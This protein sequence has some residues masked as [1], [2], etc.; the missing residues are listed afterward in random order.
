MTNFFAI[1]GWV[2]ILLTLSEVG[3]TTWRMWRHWQKGDV[4]KAT[5]SIAD[6]VLG[7]SAVLWMVVA[8]YR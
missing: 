7:V 6:V 2:L 8:I 5:I 3:M 4:E 1:Y